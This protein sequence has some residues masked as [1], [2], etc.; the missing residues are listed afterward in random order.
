M[1]ADASQSQKSAAFAR[2]RMEDMGLQDH[3]L[4]QNLVSKEQLRG[5]M[6]M[7]TAMLQR[8][9]PVRLGKVLLDLRLVS[10]SV[11]EKVVEK[12]F[13]GSA[14]CSDCGTIYKSSGTGGTGECTTCGPKTPIPVRADD[15]PKS[16]P[17]I[18]SPPSGGEP[19]SAS[20]TRSKPDTKRIGP[21]QF[22]RYEI[23]SEV[24]RGGMG[25]VYRAKDKQ[26]GEVVAMKV[27]LA[28]EGANEDEMAR[29]ER[30]ARA[31]SRLSH[32]AIVGI[33]EAGS[34]EGKP[35]ITMEYIDGKSLSR[36]LR[37]EGPLP[38]KRAL[39]ILEEVTEAVDHAH[40]KGV[41][42]RDLKPGNVLIDKTGHAHLTDFGLAKQ[43]G[44][45]SQL[46]KTG[47][48]L[49]TP[50]YMPP[51]QAAGDIHAIDARSDI[52]SLGAVLYHMLVGAPPFGGETAMQTMYHVMNTPPDPPRKKNRSI[53]R[54]METI[55]LLCLEKEAEDRYASAEALLEDV[56][57]ARSGAPI[58]GMRK[59]G[60]AKL[61]EMWQE[62]RT[63]ILVCG[64]SGTVILGLLSALLWVL[65]HR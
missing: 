56:K 15:D 43:V 55:C 53:P 10:Q 38:P 16:A 45:E 21:R 23:L 5:A 14:F 27:L 42:H 46:T 52:Y 6:K 12:E 1:G 37:E 60:G 65:T 3:L 40:K 36:I 28:G 35:F 29:F 9:E 64:V 59:S 44:T 19:P 25:V 2:V 61:A 58:R 49:G 20:T 39:E 54:D 18:V 50:A 51:E 62:H 33:R 17:T 41:I 34:I 22:G 11:L 26:N 30:E 48:Q 57:R 32:P 13:A 31:A 8:G 24:A 4:A 63:L 7:L 47:T